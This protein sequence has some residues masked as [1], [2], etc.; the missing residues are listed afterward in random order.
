MSRADYV[1]KKFY[2]AYKNLERA[3][4]DAEKRRLQAELLNL[5]RWAV[6]NKKRIAIAI[7]GRDAAGKGGTIKRFVE[8][9]MPKYLRVVEL[10]VPTKN[11]S[12]N[13]FRRYEKQMPQK[14]EIVFF[15]RSWYNRALIEPTMGYCTERQYRY[16]MKRVVPWEEQL[17]ADG[18]ILI[19]FYLSVDRDTQL[20][21][22]KERIIHPLKYWKYSK[23]DEKARAKWEVFTNYK[24]QMLERTASDA[25][26]WVVINA[27]DKMYARLACMLYLSLIHI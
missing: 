19:K 7:E 16:F 27:N 21:R 12:R 20:F 11:E 15:D 14:G 18:L 8:Y 10:G 23:N 13:W 2:S 17:I 24:T 26:P 6:E 4:Y 22:F 9:L 25:S 1:K 5:Q 3:V